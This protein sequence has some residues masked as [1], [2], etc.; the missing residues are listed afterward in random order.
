MA[1]GRKQW[2]ACIAVTVTIFV[3]LARGARAETSTEEMRREL[4]TMRNELRRMQERIDRQEE[5]I[6][7]LETEKAAPPAAVAAA[8]AP[9]PPARPPWSPAAPIA[10]F[11]TGKSYLNLSFDALV[12]GGWSTRRDVTAIQT[13]DHDPLQR[14]FTIPNAELFLDGAVDPYFKGAANLV[15]KLDEDNETEV[16]LEEVY[17]TTTALPWNLQAKAGQFFTE[18][19][20]Q[21]PQHPHAWEFVDQP[22]VLGRMFGPEG[23][24]N[25]GTRLSWL[26]PTPFYS[27]L[28]LTAQNSHGGTAFSFRNADDA[29][30]G[31][32]PVDRPVR[33]PGDLL[34]TPR[35]AASFD[36]TDSQ[37]IVTG[38]SGAF[39]PNASGTDTRTEIYGGDVFWKWKPPSQ[40][41][42]FPFVSV[43]AEALG[44]RYEAGATDGLPR[45]TLRDWGGY[46]Q[47]VYGFVQRWTAGLRGDWVSGD[48]GVFGPDENRADRFRVSP[49][50][51]F[52]PSEF[53]KIRLQYNYDHGQL[54]GDDSSVWVQ[55]EFLL[56]AHA[57]HK[58]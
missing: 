28:F 23:L 14:G 40:A 21:N 42:G 2:G 49:A 32:P 48:R 38:V 24:R 29:L 7:K 43:Q 51:T 22:L 35:Y 27:E 11:S 26:A 3:S 33:D 9:P 58:F 55:L 37:T 53:S 39:G 56:G 1:G 12:D 31:R 44:R 52:Y 34:Y 25:P 19:G 10:L 4:E 50:V 54:L 16:E 30:F 8:P 47:V 57:A 5:L 46:A 36:L 13:G 20:R 45:E 6:R 41:G 17:L 15:F 18:F